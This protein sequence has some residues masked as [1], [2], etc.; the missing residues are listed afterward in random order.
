MRPLLYIAFVLSGAAGLMYESIW[1][2][3]LG[4]FV[5]HS[6]YAQIIVLT[7][8]LGGMSLGAA[9]VGRRSERIRDPLLWYAVTELAVGLI[10]LG[11]HSVY[12][13]V[14]G[15]A[16]DALFPM[17]AG[18][19]LLGV[20]KWMIVALLV[21]PQSVLLGATFPL[22][23]AG[24]LRHAPSLPG[25]TL[26]LLYFTNSLGAAIGVLVAG[27]YLVALAGLP[28]TLT[29]AAALNLLVALV[30]MV[31]ARVMRARAPEVAPA[32]MR[33]AS[34]PATGD[35]A[36]DRLRTMLLAVTFGTAIASFVYEIAWIRMLAMVLGSATHSFEL[37]LSAFILG[38]ALGALWAGRHADRLQDPVRALGIVQWCMGLAALATLPVYLAS[39][40]WTSFL[41]H[42]LRK[43][44]EGYALFGAARYGF[45]LAVML[46]ATLC[47]GVT[48][49]LITRTLLAS[50][51]GERSIGSVYS[52]NTLGSILG[53]VLAGLLLLPL[54]GLKALLVTGATVDMALGVMLLGARA[55]AGP[56]ARALAAVA[57]ASVVGAVALS[58]L[59]NRFD[60]LLLSSGVFRHGALPGPNE[61]ASKDVVFYRDGRTASVAVTRRNGPGG[62]AASISILTNGKPDGSLRPGRYAPAQ[63]AVQRREALGED[64]S[65]QLLLPLVA[66]AH[67]PEA[68]TVAVIGQGTGMSSH[69][70]LGSP[71]VRELYT[72]EIEP[73]MIAGSRAF[74]P[75][76]KRVFDDP[77]SR[78]VVDDAKSFFAGSGR[79]FD[80]ILSEPSNP[81]VSGV[82]GLFT[83][84]FY[85]R[86]RRHLAPG[87]VFA[88]W[89]HLYEINDGLVLTVL[90]ALH[91]SF[92]AYEIYA[93]GMTDIVIVARNEPVV[94]PPQWSIL[95]L[96]AIAA[97]LQRI[98]PFTPRV[99]QAS[100]LV[101]RAA[102]APLL[103]RWGQPNS[104]Y[105]PVLDL[106]GERAR[107]VDDGATGFLRLAAEPFDV[108][109]ALIGRRSPFSDEVLV[110]VPGILRA[111]ALARSASVRRALDDPGIAPVVRPSI[112]VA[113]QRNWAYRASLADPSPP[114]NWG[115]WLRDAVAVYAELHGGSAGVAD[116]RFFAD[117][118]RYLDRHRAPAYAHDA[119][120]FLHGIAAWDF[121]EAATAA[122]RLFPAMKAGA[123]FLPADLFSDGAVVAKLKTNDPAGARRILEGMMP[124]STRTPGHLRV[125]MLDA[126]IAAGE[127][128]QAELA[129]GAGGPSPS[130]APAASSSRT[131][132]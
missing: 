99:L 91:Q 126:Y 23:S 122:D 8:F 112:E 66:L 125:R 124:R 46:P 105:Y 13:A 49:P 24:L 131:G 15:A 97:D 76:N 37:M 50:G 68:A 87:G 107:F 48:L 101:N 20:T 110:A 47:A 71:A 69:I 4:L 72:I 119:M 130:M 51:H 55:S 90:A 59:T 21:L 43:S 63:G 22:M 60:P 94:P 53:V 106:G 19:P 89:L 17:L 86:V 9:L 109:G 115:L 67:V 52:V 92:P 78:H 75:A 74:Y 39:Y 38:L 120:A 77:R 116:E 88:Q 113:R 128:R 80:F 11:F 1:S 18:G 61:A 6:A 79:Q 114:A 28:G 117:A 41:L 30:T 98:T 35:I 29:V 132:G 111:S 65:T 42:A 62:T 31:A 10:G 82:S 40:E 102:L 83:A 16:Y 25:R 100:W 118:R 127:A 64:E 70:I 58:A 44:D 54:V 26:S 56:R 27:F 129:A 3:Y 7:I 14:T 2:R 81:W 5:G 45:A 85:Q 57:A 95:N 96:P 108:V 33:V 104:D 103:D 73:E 93:T 84:E 34:R 32:P 121:S 123:P 12:G 36:P